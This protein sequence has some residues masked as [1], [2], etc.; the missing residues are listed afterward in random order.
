MS[1]L[2]GSGPDTSTEKNLEGQAQA[3]IGGA[4]PNVPIVDFGQSSLAGMTPAGRNAMLSSIQGYQ[5]IIN[6]PG[7]LDA[8]ALQAIQ[9]GRL[10][11]EQES[12]SRTQEIQD[13]AARR[14]ASSSGEAAAEQAIQEQGAAERGSEAGMQGAALGEEARQS[15][16]QGQAAT[17][18]ALAA[19]D[20]NSARTQDAFTLAND[21]NKQKMLE[22]QFIN[23]LQQGGAFQSLMS[24][25]DKTKA[26]GGYGLL[27]NGL[28]SSQNIGTMLGTAAGAFTG[29][30]SSLIGMLGSAGGAAGAA[31]GAGGDM[32]LGYGIGGGFAT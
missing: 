5:N 13:A 29:G 17:G 16:L 15:A 27:G 14:G 30:A 4:N 2:F 22:Q 12:A 24:G 20:V 32:T 11:A 6:A 18:S 8:K 25:Y 23:A 7:G 3:A 28:L 10:G 19:A 31:A 26:G 21:E 1:F 9:S